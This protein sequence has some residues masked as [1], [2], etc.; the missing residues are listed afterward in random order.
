MHVQLG[1]TSDLEDMESY[2]IFGLIDAIGKY[3]KEMNTKFE[4]YA[5]LRIRGSILD[6]IRKQNILSKNAQ[7]YVKQVQEIETE[8]KEIKGNNPS[9]QEIA[10]YMGVKSNRLSELRAYE[11]LQKSLSWE[12]LLEVAGETTDNL[13]SRQIENMDRPLLTKELAH[14]LKAALNILSEKERQSILLLYYEKVNAVEAAR[15][16]KVSVPRISQLHKKA[17]VKMRQ[18]MGDYI[19]YLQL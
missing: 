11:N 10:E 3:K 13:E 2:G 14:A 7:A 12:F 15:I 6:E 5:S 19:E 8:L 9:D 4:T 16:M 18:P 1:C 17:L